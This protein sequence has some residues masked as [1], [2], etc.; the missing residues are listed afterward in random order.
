MIGFDKEKR[1]DGGRLLGSSSL[2]FLNTPSLSLL[3]VTHGLEPSPH[4]Q[5]GVSSS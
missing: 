2:A 4:R 5:C 1:M 3:L